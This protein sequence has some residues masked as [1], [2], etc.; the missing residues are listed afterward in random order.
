MY[1][2]HSL[3]LQESCHPVAGDSADFFNYSAQ[4]WK[5]L[6]LTAEKEIAE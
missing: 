5:V 1:G 6:V 3:T 2:T 4:T